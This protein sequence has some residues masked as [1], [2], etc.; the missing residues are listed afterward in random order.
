MENTAKI[1][2]WLKN[3]VATIEGDIKTSFLLNDISENATQGMV[4]NTLANYLTARAMVITE[5][6]AIA[7][8]TAQ[9]REQ[10]SKANEYINNFTN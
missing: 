1:A 2:E 7:D 8:A 9:V 5:N 4:L 10:A 6:D 3:L